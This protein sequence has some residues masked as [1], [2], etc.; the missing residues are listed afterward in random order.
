MRGLVLERV[1]TRPNPTHRPNLAACWPVRLGRPDE[2][3]CPIRWSCAG[4]M[5]GGEGESSSAPVTVW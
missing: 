3:H 1:T 5:R 2:L 4:G